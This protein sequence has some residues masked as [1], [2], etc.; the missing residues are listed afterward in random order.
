LTEVRSPQRKLQDSWCAVMVHL[1]QRVKVPPEELSMHLGSY[2]AT[3][4]FSATVVSK[5]RDRRPL[6]GG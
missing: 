1:H 5:P 3:S 6:K 4:R 2:R